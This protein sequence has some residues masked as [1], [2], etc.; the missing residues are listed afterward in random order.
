MAYHKYANHVVDNRG[1]TVGTATVQVYNAGGTTA[2]TI[3]SD[4]AG[5]VITGGTITADA[6]DGYFEF[7]VST[8]DYAA[9][10]KFKLVTT[11][12]GFSFRERDYEGI[13]G[14]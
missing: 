11:K 4:Q 8:G 7:F 3:Y 14:L 5:T 2:A 13:V 12:A 9:G 10:S 6:T 1:F